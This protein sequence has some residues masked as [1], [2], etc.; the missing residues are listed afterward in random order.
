MPTIAAPFANT[1][2]RAIWTTRGLSLLGDQLARVALAVLVFERTGSAALTGAAYAATFLPY[3]AGPLVAGAADSRSRKSILVVLDV[4]R[5]L[6]VGAMA[7]PGMPLLWMCVLLALVTAA[8][9]VY[10]AARSAML[11][12]VL[13]DG[14][15]PTGL[16]ICTITTESAQ[17]LGFAVGGMLVAVLGARTALAADAGTFLLSA[18]I[19]A[20]WLRARPPARAADPDRARQLRS[21]TRLVMRGPK[22]RRL[23]ALAW[24]NAFWIVP[25]GL[26]APYA[27]HLGG[28]P[29]SVGLLLSALPFG[30]AAGALVL[31][32]LTTQEQRERLMLPMAVFAGLPLL[33]CVSHPGLSVS[34]A[35]WA[36]CGV[37]SA[38]NV[39]ANAAF[40]QEV[41]NACRSQAIAIVTTGMVAGQGLAVLLGGLAASVLPPWAVVSIAGGLGVMIAGSFCVIKPVRARVIDLTTP[42][43]VAVEQ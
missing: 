26:A 32:S 22:L 10:D 37:G 39:A 4:A 13:T 40:V 27:H 17:V 7:L 23:V 30:C 29:V 28:G 15:Y 16:A 42:A 6:T 41:P 5:A 25:E 33:A 1:E 43:M 31:T 38:Y 11:P 3:L 36:L 2:F 24:M 21:T 19:L 9:P 12:D 34:L 14:S 18:A 8:S 35:L 20:K